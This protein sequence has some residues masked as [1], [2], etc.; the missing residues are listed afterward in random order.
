MLCYFMIKIRNFYNNL[1]LKKKIVQN[2][3]NNQFANFHPSSPHTQRKIP[4]KRPHEEYNNNIMVFPRFSLPYVSFFSLS[5]YIKLQRIRYAYFLNSF[6]FRAFNNSGVLKRE[7]RCDVNLPSKLLYVEFYLRFARNNIRR[8][9][10][11]SNRF[12]GNFIVFFFLHSTVLYS[13]TKY[14]Y[15]V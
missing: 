10:L 7:N 2:V 8:P 1:I 13:G 11:G 15:Y 14:Y 6:V 3:Q 9:K 5:H 4:S 12:G